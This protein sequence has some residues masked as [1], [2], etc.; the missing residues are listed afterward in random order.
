MQRI[1]SLLVLALLVVWGVW[2]QI[3]T[4][5]TTLVFALLCGVALG[6]A[7]QRSRFCFY[8]HARDW[9][10]DR[11]PR[12][13]LAIVLA[14]AI[15]LVG[16]TV[17]LGGWIVNP[18][19][20]RLPPDMHIGPVSWVLV[21]AG[22]AFGLGM[23][24]SG[25]CISAHWYRLSE[26]S[27]ASP[28]AL[29]GTA[30]GFIMG[31]KSWNGLYSVAIADAPV[32]WLPGHLGYGGALLAQLAVLALVAAYLWRGFASASY[33]R[34]MALASGDTGSAHFSGGFATAYTTPR[35]PGH[36]PSLSAIWAQL[37]QGRWSYWSGGLIVGLVGAFAIIR[38]PPLGVTALLGS[39]SRQWADAQGWIPLTMHGLD[40]FAGCSTTP[41][42]S[43]LT[44]NAVLLTGIVGGAF[45]AAFLSRQ[46]IFKMPGWRD[47]VR[48]LSGGV[49]LGWGAMV[50]LGCTVGTLLSGSQA[51]ALSG[52]VFG[53]AMFVAIW[54]GLQIKRRLGV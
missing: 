25:S 50:G 35:A 20:G 8:C 7:F 1:A 30:L 37:W 53:A 18:S 11:D 47:V 34:K 16:Y 43:F 6:V 29:L 15:G 19:A 21:L 28:F 2:L 49:L 54:A 46:F 45:V 48:G 13:M 33:Q 52:W 32:V 51:G 23:V 4:G 38:M 39:A 31:F 36:V 42:S 3:Q 14:I 12:G 27:A 41:Q 9:L 17:V 5:G 44:P 22:A 24:V 26:G 40:G 10:E